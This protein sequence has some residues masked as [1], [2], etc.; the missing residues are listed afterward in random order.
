MENPI[1]CY[2]A[3]ITRDEIRQAVMMGARKEEEV[4]LITGKTL[5]G[6]CREK[7]PRGICCKEEFHREI[8]AALGELEALAGAL[9]GLG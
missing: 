9:F 7:H 4:R 1:I 8:T 2:C 3:G 6:H 5:Q